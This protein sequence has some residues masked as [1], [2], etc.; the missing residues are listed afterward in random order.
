MTDTIGHIVCGGGGTCL[1]EK[2]IIIW[3]HEIL[4]AAV[5]LK[6]EHLTAWLVANKGFSEGKA[7]R[8]ALRMGRKIQAD[9]DRWYADLERLGIET[10]EY[11]PHAENL[12]DD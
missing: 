6:H 3:D 8:I 2:T 1:G 10:T 12:R 9:A 11:E 7:E 4:N 5:H